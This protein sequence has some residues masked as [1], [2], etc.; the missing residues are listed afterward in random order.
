[1]ARIKE[2]GAQSTDAL[3]KAQ[4]W[5]AEAAHVQ[6]TGGN[7]GVA[8]GLLKR[9]ESALPA[10][11]SYLLERSLL[12][13]LGLASFRMG[14]LDEALGL[15]ERLE[16]LATAKAEPLVIAN[17]RFNRLN[18]LSI[19]ETLLPSTGARPRLLQL[20]RESL[21]TAIAAQNQDIT[22]KSHRAIAELLGADATR[23][24][25]ALE[26]ADG[27]VRLAIAARQPNDEA[28]CAWLQASL[29]LE[30]VPRAA[31]A[32]DNHWGPSVPRRPAA[33]A[34]AFHRRPGRPI[35]AVAVGIHGSAGASFAAAVLRVRRDGR[36]TNVR[37][38]C[39]RSFS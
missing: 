29:L 25:E 17:A 33:T 13:S 37:V 6:D 12:I 15:Y 19:R 4:A 5:V 24:D 34:I 39:A 22:I 16:R 28:I 2:I 7:L 27:C 31:R 23:R 30:R 3:V 38:A 9:A 32:R 21:A 11:S 35:P 20:A 10:G 36:R 14:R 26:H 8:Y 18:T 1:M